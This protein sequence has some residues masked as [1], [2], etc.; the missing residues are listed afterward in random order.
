MPQNLNPEEEKYNKIER[1][2]WQAISKYS[3]SKKLDVKDVSSKL[4]H[5]CCVQTLSPPQSDIPLDVLYNKEINE[6]KITEQI[7]QAKPKPITFR[8]L[9]NDE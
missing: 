1:E 7:L 9:E 8:I 3:K 6:I 2:S 4:L 5:L